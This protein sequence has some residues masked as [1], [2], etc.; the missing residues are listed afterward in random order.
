MIAVVFASAAIESS[1]NDLF[2]ECSDDYPSP[3][4]TLGLLGS[5]ELVARLGVKERI[6]L[7]A[8]LLDGE[9]NPFGRQPFRTLIY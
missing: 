9:W 3:L 2:D 7:M 4:G 1:V 8:K 5:I 6:R